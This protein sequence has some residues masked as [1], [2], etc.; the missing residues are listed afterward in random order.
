MPSAALLTLS[1]CLTNHKAPSRLRACFQ[2]WLCFVALVQLV[3]AVLP[4]DG[5]DR[6]AH[7]FRPLLTCSPNVLSQYYIESV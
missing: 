3:G 6:G 7:R 2:V 5:L 1:P 4:G